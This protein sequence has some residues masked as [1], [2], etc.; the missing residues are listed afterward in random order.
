M[1][2]TNSL[3]PSGEPPL[4][5]IRMESFENG[6]FSIT[7]LTMV[8]FAEVESVWMESLSFFAVTLSSVMTFS[9]SFAGV[10]DGWLV[11]PHPLSPNA[12]IISSVWV[13]FDNLF[14][15]FLWNFCACSVCDNCIFFVL[16]FVQF[17]CEFNDYLVIMYVRGDSFLTIFIGA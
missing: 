1:G 5:W 15:T 4:L 7:F 13:Y 2:G 14:M 12:A 10:V 9:E 17:L 3:Q 11:L 8:S 6:I 16:F